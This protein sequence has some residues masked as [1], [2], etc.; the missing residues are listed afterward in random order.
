[1]VPPVPTGLGGPRTQA[2]E[3]HS[4]NGQRFRELHDGWPTAAASCLGPWHDSA[5]RR[6]RPEEDHEGSEGRR[7]SLNT[8]ISLL[9]ALPPSFNV[10][11]VKRSAALPRAKVDHGRGCCEQQP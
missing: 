4:R 5:G 11:V 2:G 6:T 8:R 7:A 1:M 9:Q 10:A 3:D